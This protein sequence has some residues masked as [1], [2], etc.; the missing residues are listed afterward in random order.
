MANINGNNS[1]NTLIG[2]AFADNIDARGGNDFVDAGDGD[3]YVNGGNGNDTVKGGRG[4][5]LLFGGANN[6]RLNGGED[7]DQ[8]D[9]GTGTDWADFDGGAAVTVDLMAGT[10]FGQGNDTLFNIENVL[11]SSFN[12]TIKGNGFNNRLEGADGDDTFIA[13]L[14]SDIIRG[15]AGV[16][17]ISFAQLG[18]AA[19]VSLA[20]GTYTA[21]TATG[22]LNSVENVT[23]SALNDTITGNAANNVIDGG[24][25]SDILNG[26]AGIDTLKITANTAA[27]YNQ[28]AFVNLTTGTSQSFGQTDTI[29][30][31]ENVIGSDAK[32]FI[33]GN[34][35]NN[36]ISSGAETDVIFATLGVDAY[37]GGAGVFDSVN[38]TGQPGATA[39]LATGL[40]SFDAN[41]YGTM[42]NIE[43]LT[44]GAGNDILTGNAALNKIDGGA[45]SDILAGGL[46]NDQMWAGTGSDR[47]IADGGND[48]LSGNYSFDGTRDNA[49]DIFEIRTTA[50]IVT[51]T[52]FKAGVDKIDFTDFNLGNSTYWTASAAQSSPSV[53]TLTLTGQAQ[54]VVTIN[55]QGVS[56]GS[57]MTLNDMIGGTLDLIAAPPVN[58]NGNGLAD[59]F[60]ILPQATGTM[61]I[62]SFEDGLDRLDLTFLN[63]PDWNGSQGGAQDGSTLFQFWNTATGDNFQ[64]HMEGVGFGLITQPDIII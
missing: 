55:L 42:I 5:D 32:D 21:G 54:E 31:F 22:T 7:N 11:G 56:N 2:T 47:L 37:D 14:G 43:H 23:G 51:I 36:V 1:A 59:I 18:L 3:D 46:G 30:N 41:N 15:D 64:L 62:N 34:A 20:T 40:Y 48:E 28:G 19:T 45:G 63:Q 35:G 53:T 61:T 4:N 29:S 26:G 44:G 25:G 50:G 52:D 33:T 16:D 58:P 6:D 9:G 13:S 10:A 12:D 17:L 38:F 39:N 57:A 8:L 49:S 24:A 27:P 60:V